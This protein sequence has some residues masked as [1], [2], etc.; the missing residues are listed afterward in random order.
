MKQ[1]LFLLWTVFFLSSCVAT[2]HMVEINDPY[3]DIKSIKLKQNLI[4][5]SA[6][7]NASISG[8][9]Y[10]HLLMYLK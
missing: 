9:R 1:S 2:S 7:K 5:I 10:F 8:N 4:G 6:E 3:K